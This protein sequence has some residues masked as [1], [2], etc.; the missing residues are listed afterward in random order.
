MVFT[1]LQLPMLMLCDAG[2]L[3]KLHN[4]IEVCCGER[5]RVMCHNILADIWHC[6]TICSHTHTLPGLAPC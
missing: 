4:H 2:F 3:H 5:S 6:H 1:L